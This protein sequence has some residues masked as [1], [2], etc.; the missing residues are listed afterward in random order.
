MFAQGQQA[1]ADGVHG[2]LV[3]CVQREDRRRD[4]LFVGE[5][6]KFSIYLRLAGGK[7]PSIY[8]PTADEPGR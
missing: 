5:G 1:V 7:V 2:R 3:A 6:V 8:G 4:N